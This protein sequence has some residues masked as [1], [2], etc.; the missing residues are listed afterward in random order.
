MGRAGG[1]AGVHA[2]APGEE[3]HRSPP[4]AAAARLTAAAARLTAAAARLG[5]TIVARVTA[6]VAR[7]TAAAADVKV[8]STI[9]W[10][11]GTR[12]GLRL[13]LRRGRGRR[14]RLWR[15]ER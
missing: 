13:R 10:R 3:L 5:L 9:E 12:R 7:L 11:W 1:R 15:R 2:P 14:R 6:A 4:A 8:D